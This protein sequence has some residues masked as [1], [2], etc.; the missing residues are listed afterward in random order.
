[1]RFHKYHA[2][3]NDYI[4]LDPSEVPRMPVPEQ[5]RRICR[6]NYGVELDITLAEDFS[7]TMTGPVTRV[8]DGEMSYEILDK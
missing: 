2:L 6:R 7:V 5:I 3:G 1:M 4:V 8:A